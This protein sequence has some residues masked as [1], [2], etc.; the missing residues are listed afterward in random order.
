MIVYG[1]NSFAL[2][3]CKPSQ[4]G[5][6]I[7]ADKLY[8]IE[9]RQ[10]YFHL[11]WIPVFGIGK[12]WVLRKHTDGELYEPTPKLSKLLHSFPLKEKTPWYTYSFLILL[13]AAS[14]IFVIYS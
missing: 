8:I 6:P 10:R 11:F 7:E 13:L 12:I 1:H 3:T 14:V 4:L 5:L 9:R 2:N